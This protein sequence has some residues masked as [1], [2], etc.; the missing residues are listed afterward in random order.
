[1]IDD[2]IR[3]PTPRH[4]ISCC[5]CPSDLTPDIPTSSGLCVEVLYPILK[6]SDW[7]SIANVTRHLELDLSLW[8]PQFT[9]D[10]SSVLCF[11]LIANAFT[12]FTGNNWLILVRVWVDGKCVVKDFIQRAVQSLETC[13]YPLSRFCKVWPQP[14][15]EQ[16]CR[17]LFAL[18]HEWGRHW[19]KI[20]ACLRYHCNSPYYLTII[21]YVLTAALID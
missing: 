3:T 4:G 1:M 15:V 17:L 2:L 13:I 5:F 14:V 6:S 7:H 9:S 11:Y 16:C 20:T 10:T 18:P 8:K 12:N 21:N 19:S